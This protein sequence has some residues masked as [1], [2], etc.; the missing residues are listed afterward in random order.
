MV[1]RKIVGYNATIIRGVVGLDNVF[2]TLTSLVS[3]IVS[4]IRDRPK[5]PS[6]ATALDTVPGSCISDSRHPPTIRAANRKAIAS[7]NKASLGSQP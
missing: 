4:V 7:P 3:S 2:Q 1:Q 5:S 6:A